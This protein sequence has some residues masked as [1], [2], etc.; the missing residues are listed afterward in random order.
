MGYEFRPDISLFPDS[1][2]SRSAVYRKPAKCYN[3]VRI[4]V[5]N[6]NYD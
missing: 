1:P 4:Y 6:V 5:S 3:D 2:E